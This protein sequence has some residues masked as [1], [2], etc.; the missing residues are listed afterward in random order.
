MKIEFEIMETIALGKM[1]VWEFL[2]SE[3]FRTELGKVIDHETEYHDR[4][5]R[6]AF[7]KKLRLQRNPINRLRERQVFNVEDMTAAYKLI[8]AKHLEGFSATERDYIKRVCMS[9]YG[10]VV[11]R[12][13]KREAEKKDNQ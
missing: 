1:T 8:I 12:Q 10:E 9:A 4:M 2:D 3:E 6:V 7:T 13:K 5:M 11:A